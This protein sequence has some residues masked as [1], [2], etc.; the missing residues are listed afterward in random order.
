MTEYIGLALIGASLIGLVWR[1]LYLG[2]KA[3]QQ[4]LHN[5][6]QSWVDEIVDLFDSDDDT[7]A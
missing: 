5:A 4:R 7:T 1:S 2:R 3:K 6:I